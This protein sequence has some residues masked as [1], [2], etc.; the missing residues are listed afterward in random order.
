MEINVLG[1]KSLLL[2]LALRRA[3]GM[4]SLAPQDMRSLHPQGAAI[5]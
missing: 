4:C 1:G 5:Q 2:E 3:L